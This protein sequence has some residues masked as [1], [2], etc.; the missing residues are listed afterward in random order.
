[1]LTESLEMTET[2]VKPWL[3]TKQ[4][5]VMLTESLEMTETVVKPWLSTKQEEVML[6][7]KETVVMPNKSR[8]GVLCC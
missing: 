1:M 7:V 3:S 2:V 5:E 8:T 4:E 6:D